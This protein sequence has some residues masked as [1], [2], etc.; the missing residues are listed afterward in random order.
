MDAGKKLV[1][2]RQFAHAPSFAG[3]I[4]LT[5]SELH[6]RSKICSA[7]QFLFA[8]ARQ[9]SHLGQSRIKQSYESKR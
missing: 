3:A 2:E 7:M 6:V 9:L 4:A 1:T 8:E 5:Y